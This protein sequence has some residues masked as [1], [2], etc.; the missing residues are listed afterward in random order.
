MIITSL[1]NSRVKSVVHLRRRRERDRCGK[2]IV[3]GYRELL[4]ARQKQYP[5]EELYFCPEWF[6]GTNEGALLEAFQ[7]AGA[8]LIE[9]GRDAFRKMAY[10]DRPEGL[11]GVGPQVR[12]TL[13]NLSLSTVPFLLVAEAIEKPGNLGTILRSA[14]A[15]GVDGLILCDR[16]TDIFNPNVVRASTGTLFSVTVAEA[17]GTQAGRWLAARGIRT[18]AATPHAG[19]LYTA[20][21]MTGPVAIV[22]GTEQVGLSEQWMRAADLQVR[23]P[24]LGMADSLNVATATTLLLYEVVRQRGLEGVPSARG[25]SVAT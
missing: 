13:G 8:E 10:R 12:H 21:D 9:V 17:D 7:G 20:V 6:Q 18:V 5:V 15:T 4:R 22:V 11:L 24:M 1:Q 19:P 23:I 25:G 16:C 2:V 3:E 14:D